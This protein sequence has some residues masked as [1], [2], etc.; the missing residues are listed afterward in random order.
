MTRT[1]TKLAEEV[2][3]HE[4]IRVEG[5]DFRIA[6]NYP[7]RTNSNLVVLATVRGTLFLFN[8]TSE[9]KVVDESSYTPLPFD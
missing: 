7:M 6:D 5:H 1:T 4:V 3:K 9:V 8:K 2:K